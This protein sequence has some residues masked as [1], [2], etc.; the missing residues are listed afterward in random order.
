M[1]TGFGKWEKYLIL[2]QV[3]VPFIFFSAMGYISSPTRGWTH[4]L[5]WKRGVLI[6]ALP[7][8]FP[9]VL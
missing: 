2:H 7:V 5:Q 9:G 1:L 3:Q 4:A 6:T 8:S